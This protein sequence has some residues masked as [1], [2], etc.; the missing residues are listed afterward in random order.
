MVGDLFGIG[1]STIPIIVRKR[2][3]ANRI[4]LRVLIFRKPTF[5][6]MKQIEKDFKAYSI[7]FTLGIIDRSH[8][9]IIAPSYDFIAY[10]C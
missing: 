2:C 10:Y 7:V 6:L 1:L 5:T 4:Y 8:F 9:P 3:E